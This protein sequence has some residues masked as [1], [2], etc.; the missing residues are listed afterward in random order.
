MTLS[1]AA[2]SPHAVC[3]ITARERERAVVAC[4]GPD[5]TAPSVQGTGASAHISRLRDERARSQLALRLDTPDIEA[6]FSHAV[7]KDTLVKITCESLRKIARQIVLASGAN[8]DKVSITPLLAR[9]EA[10]ISAEFPAA[11]NTRRLRKESA[12]LR[13]CK[14]SSKLIELLEAEIRIPITALRAT[15]AAYVA[16]R[17]SYSVPEFVSLLSDLRSPQKT[18]FF[19]SM[20]E[21]TGA[22]GFEFMQD[23]DAYLEGIETV[24]SQSTISAYRTRCGQLMRSG[25]EIFAT[26]TVYPAQERA[27]AWSLDPKDSERVIQHTLKLSGEKTTDQSAGESKQPKNQAQ[28][29]AK[30]PAT[31]PDNLLYQFRNVAR[32]VREVAKSRLRQ[33]A[34][35]ESAPTSLIPSAA[36]SLQN[37]RPSGTSEAI[38]SELGGAKILCQRLN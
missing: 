37:M 3:Q 10:E 18:I 21:Q 9:Y 12:F 14:V 31:K 27:Y 24:K 22:V 26:S 5:T 38:F 36:Q 25:A 2:S 34:A 8:P 17:H 11:L 15:V 29:P 13:T 23:F 33:Q 4:F 16:A 28:K 35:G 7:V 20:L 19:S 32:Y 6:Y 1:P 30:K